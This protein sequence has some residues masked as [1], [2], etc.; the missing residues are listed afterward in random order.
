MNLEFI[1]GKLGEI[2]RW[3]TERFRHEFG[4]LGL[5]AKIKYDGYQD[6]RAGASSPPLL[7]CR[8]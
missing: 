3:D 7:S 8:V 2:M 5:M 4:W 1:L 6:F